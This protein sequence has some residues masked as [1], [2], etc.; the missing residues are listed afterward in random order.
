MK[1]H[2]GQSQGDYYKWPVELAGN[3]RKDG[4][5]LIVTTLRGSERVEWV[6]APYKRPKF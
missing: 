4:L 1:R 5:K 2:V 6:L 3:Y